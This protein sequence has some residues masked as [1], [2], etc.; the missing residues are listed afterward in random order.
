M[1]T[2]IVLGSNSDIAQGLLPYL[3][4][5]YETVVGWSRSQEMPTVQWDLCLIAIGTVAPVGLWHDVNARDW[6][7][8]IESNLVEPFKRLQ[9]IWPEHNPGATVIFMAGSN[10]QMVMPGYSGYST[11]KMALLKLVEQMDAETPDAK[12]VALGP[13]TILTKIH[14]ATLD[15]GWDN[16]KLKKAM[17][18]QKPAD[19]ARLYKCMQWIIAQ[20]KTVVGGRNIC[21]SDPW[22]QPR[23][24]QQMQRNRDLFKLRRWEGY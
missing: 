11:G 19:Y 6:Q 3:S 9:T 20:P 24:E 18:E 7:R 17:E 2:C 22:D 8:S 10:P 1:K 21:V 4:R 15:A 23:T 16:P 12:F 14:K 5:D 13:G